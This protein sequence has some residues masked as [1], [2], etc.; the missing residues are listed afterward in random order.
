MDVKQKNHF[1][2][3][4]IRYWGLEPVARQVRTA[5]E[6]VNLYSRWRG[7]NRY[8]N[9]L[10][11]FEL[12]HDWDEVRAAGVR[13][14][15]LTAL[16]AYCASGLPL[17]H[18]SLQAEVARTRD[19]ELQRLLDWSLAVSEDID[20]NMP[21]APPFPWA[22]RALAKMQPHSDLIVVSQTPVAALV[23]EWTGHGMSHLVRLIA[24]QEL[25]SKTEQ[26]R[27]ATGGR[28]PAGR[29]LMI[30]DAPGDLVAAQENQ[31]AFFPILP[32]HEDQ[33]WQRFHEEAYDL[34]LRGAYAGP[35][36]EQLIQTFQASLS[37]TPPW[38]LQKTVA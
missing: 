35:Y 22:L 9:L 10:L 21:P 20:R 13:L 3:L 19:P 17:G 2:P 36:A 34:F 30:G 14:P 31:A 29:V 37:D 26:I 5:A 16:R 32:G 24:G 25:G 1:H 18:P 33:S 38:K 27:R 15:D 11:T 28:Y 4:I 7:K 8:P 6:F 12:L 23:K